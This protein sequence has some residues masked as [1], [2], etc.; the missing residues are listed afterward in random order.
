LAVPRTIH[1][2]WLGPEPLPD[3]HRPWIDSWRRHHPGWEHRL[4]T[5]VDLPE[6]PVR[7]EVLDRLRAPVERA[8]I[9]RLEILFRHGGIYADTDLECLRPVDE[10]LEGEEFVGVCLKPGRVTNTFIASAANHSL[11]GRALYELRPMDVYWTA[12]AGESI[13]EGAGPPLL[14]RLVAEHPGL[15]LLEPPLFFPATP[16]ERE[17]AYA[18]HH[19]ERSW[20][21]ATAMRAA[22][23]QAERRLELA[24][25]QIDEERRSHAATRKRLERLE[26]RL[27]RERTGKLTIWDRLDLLH[28]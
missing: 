3:L 13:K 23:G 15:S 9:L 24:N 14:R 28:R 16:Q 12:T 25:Q 19:M 20:H 26:A 10:L 1:Q 5:E 8:D 2:I 17:R 27:E 4:W 18:V 6:D 11:L 7:R 22:I 21:N